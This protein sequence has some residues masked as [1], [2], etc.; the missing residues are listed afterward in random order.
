LEH[1]RRKV[2]KCHPSVVV[3]LRNKSVKNHKCN[4]KDNP[5]VTTDKGSRVL[6]ISVATDWWGI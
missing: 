2:T 5:E 4:L 3:S 6:D 1:Q